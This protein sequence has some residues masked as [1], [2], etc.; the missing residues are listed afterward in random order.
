M[1]TEVLF[2]SKNFNDKNHQ[3]GSYKMKKVGHFDLLYECV[4][5]DKN[6]RGHEVYKNHHKRRRIK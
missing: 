3:R 5:S 1:Q 4:S 6:E 2:Y